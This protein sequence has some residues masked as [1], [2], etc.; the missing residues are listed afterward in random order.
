MKN[1]NIISL[2]LEYECVVENKIFI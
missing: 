2:V 1:K